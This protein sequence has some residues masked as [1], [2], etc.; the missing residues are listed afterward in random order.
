M[1]NAIAITVKKIH[2]VTIYSFL[3][4]S[5]IYAAI[6]TPIVAILPLMMNQRIITTYLLGSSI[7][8]PITKVANIILLISYRYLAKFC[9]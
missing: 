1:I 8:C 3:L 5:K 2:K 7:I 6:K 4:P 9:Y